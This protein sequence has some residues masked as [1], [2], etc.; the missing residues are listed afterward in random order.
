[1]PFGPHHV[2]QGVRIGGVALGAGDAV[3]LPVA[4]DLQRID[5]IDPVP[6]RKQRLHP[7]APVGL[8]PDHDLPRIGVLRQLGPDQLVQPCNPGDPLRKPG[9]AQPPSR[10]VLHLDVVVVLGPIVPDQQ[11]PVPLLP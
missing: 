5:R 2:G 10:L 11:Q 4:G 9:L 1:M 6:G 7:R 8:D 3:P